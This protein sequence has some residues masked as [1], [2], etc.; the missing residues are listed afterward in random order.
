MAALGNTFWLRENPLEDA[1]CLVAGAAVTLGLFVTLSLSQH[2]N[3]AAPAADIED[4]RA[5]AL[6][7]ELPPPPP[8]TAQAT[9]GDAAAPMP[10]A[11][12]LEASPSDSAVHLAASP[13]QV[14]LPPLPATVPAEIAISN[15]YPAAKPS[16]AISISEQQI[17]QQ[18]E[19]DQLPRAT[20][21]SIQFIPRALRVNL[22]AQIRIVF[23]LLL[24]KDG[25]ASSARVVKS[26]GVPALD[27]LIARSVREDWEFSPAIRR[28]KAVRCFVQQ[29][30]LIKFEAGSPLEV[31]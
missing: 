31:H 16:A 19:V 10:L 13:P 6:P 2:H 26:S 12:G 17:Y 29:S 11:T 8:T 21:Q 3:R 30:Y 14:E 25:H 18:A 5:Y 9:G 4:L 15:S 7:P 23:I 28:G 20:K 22:P 1:G 27:E 24:E